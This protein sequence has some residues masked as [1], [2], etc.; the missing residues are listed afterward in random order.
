MKVI[1]FACVA[2]L[3]LPAFAQRSYESPSGL[4]FVPHSAGGG[5]DTNFS[6]NFESFPVQGFPVNG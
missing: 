5:M 6:E 2:G 3:A 1:V 4:Y